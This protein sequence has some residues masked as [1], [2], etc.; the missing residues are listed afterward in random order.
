VTEDLDRAP[1]RDSTRSVDERVADL[2]DR[3]TLDEKA[4]QLTSV[5]LAVDPERGEVAPAQFAAM[6][7]ELADQMALLDLGVGQVTRPLGTVP[8]DPVAGATLVNDLQR[9][10]V[11]GSRLGIP[12]LFHEEC[13][14][15][16]MAQ[17][18]T[19]FPSPLNF[20]ATWDPDLVERVGA[21]IGRQMRMVG[22]RQGLG[23]VADVARDA[24]WGRIE[25]TMGED[26]YLVGLMVSAYV[27]GLQGDRGPA[28]VIATLKHFVGYSFSEGGRNVAPAHV[29]PRELADV[30]MLPFEMAIKLGHAD[31][32]MNSY[33][34]VD[35][36][37]PGSSYHLLTEVLRDR[38]GFDGFTVA[39]YG[40]ISFLH[41]F[42]GVAEGPVDAAATA[43]AAGLDV[44]L[45]APAA[46]PVGIPA[47]IDR[48]LL[49]VDEVDRAVVRVLRAKFRLGL[50][51]APYVDVGAIDLDTPADRALAGE[52]ARRSITLL[53]ND[54]VLPLD[55]DRLG[56]VAVI[57]PNADDPM[58]LF[59]NYSFEN[60]LVS[61]H[62]A[63]ATDVVTAP[64]VLDVLR[65]RLG[66]DRVGHER[67]AEVMTDE[68]DGIDDAVALAA[69]ADVAV[70]VVGDK[71]GHFKLGTVG[72]GTDTTDLGL[73]GGQAA[74]VDAVLDTGTPTVVVLLNGRPFA[75][76]AVAERAAA[77][78]E[79][80]FP[81]QDGAAAVVDVLFGAAEPGGRTTV[82]F[83]R[84]AGA[85][86]ISYDHKP[87]APGF[88]RQDDFGFVFPF[89][90]GLTYTTF[91]YDDLV[92]T[93][94]EVDVAGTFTV[95]C[96][97]T[98]TGARA[99]TEVVQLYL[100]DPVASVARPVLQLRGF[101]RVP[102]EPGASTEVT[103]TVPTDLV[104]FTGVDLG[105]IV[106]PGVIEVRVGASSGDLRL[107][108]EVVLVGEV[109]EAGEDRALVAEVE[110]GP[111]SGG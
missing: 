103:F 106:E 98:N 80:W 51:E 39:D 38:W 69:A 20:G 83:A 86:P 61:T 28:G 58:A 74:L 1:Y 91:A 62:F 73:P 29:G 54:G 4:A 27:R 111:P 84:T 43:L 104:A 109:R 26:P 25:E 50:F 9:R 47:A 57:G 87:L 5:W 24:R 107:R 6:F 52:V 3:M 32:V 55:D 78:V 77:V 82:S 30:F 7:G 45:P 102:L 8:V 36:E 95:R 34:E 99:G 22:D 63:E 37:Q 56:R 48:G 89:G 49:T 17:G 71:A 2:V 12:V 65:S 41:L 88:P 11:E 67:G 60:H 46:Y 75:L 72:E 23:P 108:G 97:V 96:T 14:T 90:H 59:G 53:A 13:L 44:E 19:S 110:V 33:Q 40:A 100:T 76:G 94:A 66:V 16:L 21:T 79:A 35:G 70:V 42:A 64:T 85:M 92:V 18:A 10:V 101:A 68:R 81:G 93:P 105:R 15:G 31:S